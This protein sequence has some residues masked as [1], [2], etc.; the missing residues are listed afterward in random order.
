[1]GAVSVYVIVA[2]NIP[3]E[4]SIFDVIQSGVDK[5]PAVVPCSRLDADGLVDERALRKGLVGDGDSWSSVSSWSAFDS[6][7][8]GCWTVFELTVLAEKGDAVSINAPNHI[9]DRWGGQFRKNL[10]LLDVKENDRV[11]RR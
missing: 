5:N 1:V 2:R 11:R 6:A 8:S 10:L 3:L 9:L 4:Q 7:H